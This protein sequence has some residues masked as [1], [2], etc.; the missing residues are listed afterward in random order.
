MASR[1]I[2]TSTNRSRAGSEEWSKGI[3]GTDVLKDPIESTAHVNESVRHRR[4]LTAHNPCAFPHESCMKRVLLMQIGAFLLSRP[5]AAWRQA[6]PGG[7]NTFRALHQSRRLGAE[8]G[9]GEARVSVTGPVY[10]AA[11]GAPVVKLFTKD[12]CTLCDKVAMRVANDFRSGCVG[13]PPTRTP[14]H[15]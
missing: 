12:G 1:T 15:R 9:Q 2:H 3:A 13:H 11:E 10:T 14:Q 7:F 8:T 4:A 6:A 5:A